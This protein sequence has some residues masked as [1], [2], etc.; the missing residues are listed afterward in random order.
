MKSE[1]QK[2]KKLLKS[3]KLKAKSL[4][5]K[6]ASEKQKRK[7][8]DFTFRLCLLVLPSQNIFCHRSMLRSAMALF[9]P[10]T[11]HKC[12]WISAAEHPSAVKNVKI[13]LTS[14][15]ESGAILNSILICT[16]QLL[17]IFCCHVYFFINFLW[18]TECMPTSAGSPAS[19][20]LEKQYIWRYFSNAPRSIWDKGGEN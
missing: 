16:L 12:Q 20:I 11:A 17:N 2:W 9:F 5:L 19:P 10:Y 1:K 3:W 18:S 7:F 13:L 8:Y 6:T 4:I 14:H 15:L